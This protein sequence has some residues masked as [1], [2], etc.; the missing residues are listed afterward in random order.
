M[1]SGAGVSLSGQ[2]SASDMSSP[3]LYSG[4]SSSSSLG[5]EGESPLFMQLTSITQNGGEQCLPG[6]QG[7]IPPAA[8][9]P[10]LGWGGAFSHWGIPTDPTFDGG[11]VE[12]GRVEWQ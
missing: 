11:K 2:D 7:G 1:Q 4:S 12:A 5:Q 9:L 3:S 6:S 10:T 8:N